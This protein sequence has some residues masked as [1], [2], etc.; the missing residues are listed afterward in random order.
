MLYN[1][2]NLIIKPC[3][4]DILTFIERICWKLDRNCPN[5][6]DPVPLFFSLSEST[7]TC[8]NQS[9]RR[10]ESWSLKFLMES[11][12]SIKRSDEILEEQ[13]GPIQRTYSPVLKGIIV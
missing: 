4:V 9:K 7:E 13:V 2:I 1:Q 11:E 5:E 3:I 12:I 6:S 10:I 8:F